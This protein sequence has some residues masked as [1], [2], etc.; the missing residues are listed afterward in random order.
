MKKSPTFIPV[1]MILLFSFSTALPQDW[2]MANSCKERTSYV[3]NTG[4][5]GLPF[6][7]EIAV[8][9]SADE[10][11]YYDGILYLSV[12]GSPNQLHAVDAQ[13]G[14]I[15]WTF[16]IQNSAGSVGVIPAVSDS[17]VLIGGQ[18]ADGIFA[19]MR[20]CGCPAWSKPIGS[21]YTRNPI[22]DGEKIYVV[23]DSLYCLGLFDGTTYWTQ[24]VSGQFTPAVDE[25]KVYVFG[26][27]YLNAFDKENGNI[28]WQASSSYSAFSQVATDMAMVYA[29]KGSSV[30]AYDKNSG[31]EMWSYNLPS[32]SL[33]GVNQ[34]AMAISQE[35]ICLAI[36]DNGQ[37]KGQVTAI[38]RADGTYLWHQEQGGE[39]TFSPT[40]ADGMV[41]IINWTEAAIYGFDIT[42]GTQVFHDD[43]E[44]YKNQPVVAGEALYAITSNSIAR[45]NPTPIG[46]DEYVENQLTVLVSPNPCNDNTEFRIELETPSMVVIEIYDLPGSPA[47][48]TEPKMYDKGSCRIGFDTVDLAPGAYIYRIKLEG[49][50]ICGK[51]LKR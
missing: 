31:I 33:S 27:G 7:K 20:V 21:M 28:I 1:F 23:T 36:W 8:Q 17:I 40:I 49:K 37:G 44:T 25:S 16:T 10:M 48:K 29:A 12:N 6:T 45:F 4:I 15:L 51:I 34:G 3:Q 11:S 42:N 38:N 50:E 39:G 19:I 2:P 43:S 46:K 24:E 26:N 9:E 35:V 18:S 14:T 41:F 32:G 47:G 13:T 5:L 30:S 22:I